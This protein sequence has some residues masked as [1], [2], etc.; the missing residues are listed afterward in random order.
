MRDCGGEMQAIPAF[1]VLPPILL[2]DRFLAMDSNNA[3][4]TALTSFYE[5]VGECVDADLCDFWTARALFGN[6]IVTFYHNM[7]P[8]LE[9][10]AQSGGNVNGLL[11]FVDR[12][13]DADRGAV[14][15]RFEWRFLARE[16]GL[17]P[18]IAQSVVE[19]AARHDHDIQRKQDAQAIALRDWADRIAAIGR[20]ERHRRDQQDARQID[21]AKRIR[22]R[23]GTCHPQ[24]IAASAPGIAIKAPNADAVATARG[25]D[26][27]VNVMAGTPSEPPPIPVAADTPPITTAATNPPGPPG[28]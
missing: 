8:V 7:Y 23:P 17:T 1:H 24:A 11:H 10:E 18:G 5:E 16:S 22:R 2:V 12:M 6:D 14:H 25:S 21:I 4:F 19:H 20:Q 15:R 9:R 3:S 26:A 13:H 28:Q 27:P